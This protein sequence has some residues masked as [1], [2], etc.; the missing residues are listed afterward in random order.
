[1]APL[2]QLKI[3]RNLCKSLSTP[4]RNA[5]CCRWPACATS[6]RYRESC[7]QSFRPVSIQTRL[8]QRSRRWGW[9]DR[10][11]ISKPST[12][13]FFRSALSGSLLKSL[14]SVLL[15]KEPQFERYWTLQSLK[16]MRDREGTKFVLLYGGLILGILLLGAI[17]VILGW[18]DVGFLSPNSRAQAR[19][20]RVL[21]ILDYCI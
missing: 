8:M 7:S 18:F 15:L 21:Y 11:R 3:W 9:S 10:D 14:I 5:F 1:V 6:R 13:A 2:S 19:F 20:F 16:T 12:Q 17:Q 4:E